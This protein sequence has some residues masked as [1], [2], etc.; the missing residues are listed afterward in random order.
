MAALMRYFQATVADFSEW[1]HPSKKAEPTVDVD[2][3]MV[4]KYRANYSRLTPEEIAQ[5]DPELTDLYANSRP[6]SR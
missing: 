2:S 4:G 6:V 1:V 3:P 5:E